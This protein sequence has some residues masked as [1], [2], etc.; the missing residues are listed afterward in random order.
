MLLLPPSPPPLQRAA[1]DAQAVPVFRAKLEGVLQPLKDAIDK[2]RQL[3]EPMPTRLWGIYKDATVPYAWYVAAAGFC[4]PPLL[5]RESLRILW[6]SLVA[7]GRCGRAAS[8]HQPMCRS[9]CSGFVQGDGSATSKVAAVAAASGAAASHFFD[10]PIYPGSPA[11]SHN[12]RDHPACSLGASAAL[13]RPEWATAGG[14]ERGADRCNDGPS[15][16]RSGTLGRLWLHAAPTQATRKRVRRVAL[17]Q[18]PSASLVASEWP[19]WSHTM[20]CPAPPTAPTPASRWS[21]AS[22]SPSAAGASAARTAG[23]GEECP[24]E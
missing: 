9:D 6:G 2:M 10:T 18:A 11:V 5:Q 20:Q 22:V 19:S 23:P 15:C 13:P 17:P 7:R 1:V 8:P 21:K 12:W 3:T 16:R 24:P 14:W 4:Y